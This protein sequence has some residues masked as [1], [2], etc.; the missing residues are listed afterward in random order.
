MAIREV[1]LDTN[2]YV[3]FKRDLP[4]A[5]EII[6]HAP[7]IGLN[8]I[9]LGELLGGFAVGS[10]EAANRQELKSFLS[11]SRVRLYV[12][13][14]DTSS[15]YAAVYLSLRKKGRP[16][17]TND[18]WIAATALQHNLAVFTYDKH[19]REV[20]GIVVGNQLTDFVI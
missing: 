16:I 11:S 17:P 14:D 10:R 9:V 5:I 13:D 20:D 1:L 4:D 2:A 18:I 7:L 6:R 12:V 19:L 3:A 15:L 8:S